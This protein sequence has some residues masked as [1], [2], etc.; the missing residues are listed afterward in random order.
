MQ[1]IKAKSFFVD[2]R[3]VSDH[4]A[5]I[6]TEQAVVLNHMTNEERKIYDLVV[7]RFLAVL[8]EPFVYDQTTVELSVEGERFTAK[9]KV[10]KQLGWKAVYENSSMDEDE[11]SELVEQ[12][13][14]KVSKGEKIEIT[15]ISITK[16]QTTPPALFTEATLLSAMENPVQYLEKKDKSMAKVL[17]ETG[18]LGTV[19][20]RADIIDKLF[21][22]FLVEKKGKDIFITSKGKQLLELVPE[23]LQKTGI[24]SSDRNETFQN[25]K[26]VHE[27]GNVYAGNGAVYKR[28]S[29]RNKNRRRNLSP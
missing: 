12:S 19:A 7:K 5:I 20:T 26:R 23:D 17:G 29:V 13:L 25:W 9:G 14:P 22:T 6:P 10:V 15:S 4:H 8:S 16:G 1:N 21:R 2:D 3:K 27:T 28:I 11:E 18:G 24:N